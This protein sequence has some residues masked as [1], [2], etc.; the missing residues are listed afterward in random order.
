MTRME[1]GRNVEVNSVKIN[2]NLMLSLLSQQL[3]KNPGLK[4]DYPKYI[5]STGWNGNIGYVLG[6]I[7]TSLAYLLQTERV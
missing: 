4:L 1:N 7:L 2:M 3:Y 6:I 5:L